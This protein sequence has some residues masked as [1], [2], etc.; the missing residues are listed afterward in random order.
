MADPEMTAAYNQDSRDSARLRELREH[1]AAFV[2][3]PPARAHP[4]T[5]EALTEAVGLIGRDLA[6]IVKAYD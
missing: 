6:Q 2:D 4:R 1:L 3:D 5:V